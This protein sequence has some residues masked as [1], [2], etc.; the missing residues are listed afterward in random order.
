MESDTLKLEA[1]FEMGIAHALMDLG[2]EVEILEPY[3][4]AVGHAGAIV[5]HANGGLEG[6][7]DP[8][9]DGGVA[10]Y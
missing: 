7:A 3:D 5:R 9:S 8:R 10:S 2:H 4:E 1:R 6:G